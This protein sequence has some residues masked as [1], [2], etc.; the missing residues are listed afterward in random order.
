MRLSEVDDMKRH[1][2]SI[3][4]ATLLLAA[5]AAAPTAAQE[6]VDRTLP[7]PADG[8]VKVINIAGSVR[9]VGWDRNE[10]QVRGTLGEGTERLDFETQGNT[11]V[12]EVVWPQER[13]RRDRRIQGSELEI[14]VPAGSMLEVRTVSADIRIEGVRGVLELESV[15]GDVTTA[16]EPERVEAGSISGDV[17]IA[18]SRGPVYAHTV[19]GE[20][21]IGQ[22]VGSFRISTISGNATVRARQ[23]EEGEFD[24]VSG[25]L[26]FDGDLTPQARLELDSHSGTIEITVPANISAR[27]EVDTFSGS[28]QNDFGQE[29]VRTSRYAPGKELEFT[30]GSGE[31]RIRIQVFSGRVEIRKRG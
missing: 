11:T 25:S 6:R 5:L 20:I 24:S 26:R 29:A 23:V 8:N 21:S 18:A 10:V 14:Q 16:G 15:S 7:A 30:Q 9:V 3:G 12:V 28:I 2:F 17:E 1:I 4:L 19:S 31:A 13:D 27:F 22:A